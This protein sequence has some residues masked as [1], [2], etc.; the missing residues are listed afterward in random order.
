LSEAKDSIVSGNT[1]VKSIKSAIQEIIN[2]YS[3]AR[4]D[5]ISIANPMTLEEVDTITGS[6]LIS[7]AVFIEKTRL[8]DNI[9]VEI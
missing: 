9:I 2:S 5:Y 8:I 7:M 3:L 4:I 6:T 1:N